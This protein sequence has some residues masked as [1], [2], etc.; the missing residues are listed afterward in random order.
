MTADVTCGL[1][2]EQSAPTTDA[3]GAS[4]ASWGINKQPIRIIFELHA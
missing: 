2:A 4:L 3:N 1:I